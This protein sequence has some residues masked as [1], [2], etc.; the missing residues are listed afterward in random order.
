MTKEVTKKQETELATSTNLDSWGGGPEVT[1]NDFA[2]PKILVMQ[3]LSDLVTE[4]VAKFGE[5]R[6]NI[7]GELL[8]SIEKPMEIIPFHVEKVWVVLKKNEDGDFEYD[9][10]IPVDRT[11]ENWEWTG[12]DEDGHEVR[13]DRTLNFYVLLPEEVKNGDAMP[14]VISFRR[15]SSRAGKKLMTQMYVR[16]R[17]AKKVP[18][19]KVM[20]LVGRKEKNDKG[21]FVVLD[22]KVSRESTS[23]EVAS[24]FEFFKLIQEGK[25]KVD[26]SD[27]EVQKTNKEVPEQNPEEVKGEF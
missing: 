25:G 3:G 4:G 10:T 27:L 11:N 13:R 16:N 17:Q 26:N 23:E 21:T 20:N 8:G 12:L 5:F 9:S 6:D 24:A 19:A 7:N 18:A 1:S 14:Y 15:T 22:V 2:I